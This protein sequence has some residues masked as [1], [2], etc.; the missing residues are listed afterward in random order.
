MIPF[1]IIATSSRETWVASAPVSTILEFA[2]N[3]GPPKLASMAARYEDPLFE[4]QFEYIRQYQKTIEHLKRRNLTLSHDI[5]PPVET[6]EIADTKGYK[7]CKS[8]SSASESSFGSSARPSYT[9]S[10]STPSYSRGNSTKEGCS[11]YL[12]LPWIGYALYSSAKTQD[13][14]GLFVVA[15]TFLLLVK[16]IAGGTLGFCMGCL[17]GGY[18]AH[19]LVESFELL[20]QYSTQVTLLGAT[21]VG[22]LCLNK[23]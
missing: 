9:S 15:T 10:N 3:I 5:W 13:P 22:T 16:R 20:S 11:G 8:S 12:A 6:I 7:G 18:L 23:K 2:A 4:N 21:V 1:L 17:Y 14:F 19:K